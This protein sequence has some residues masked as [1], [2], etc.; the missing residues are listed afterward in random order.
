ML[1]IKFATDTFMIHTASTNLLIKFSFGL[2]LSA[3]KPF[4]L[5]FSSSTHL[6][7]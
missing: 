7:A 1:E 2:L 6:I 4:N 3:L 5:I